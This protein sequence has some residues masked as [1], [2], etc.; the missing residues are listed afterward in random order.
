MHYCGD[1]LFWF[2]MAMKG[3][4]IEI[5]KNL[6]NFRQHPTKATEN[7]RKAGEGI[8]EDI[9]IVKHIEEILGNRLNRYKKRLRHGILYRKIKRL[10][11][12]KKQKA[13]LYQSLHDT[14]HTVVIE[15]LIERSN[16]YLRLLIPTL[17]TGKRDRL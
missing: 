8:K 6:N 5:Y 11:I 13:P 3:Q 2:E 15:Y 7:S 10:P 9:L 4:V 17:T 1:W 14:L 12:N 16:Q